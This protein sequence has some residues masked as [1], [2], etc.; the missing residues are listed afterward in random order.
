MVALLNLSGYW[1]V[2]FPKFSEEVNRLQQVD[3]Q[4]T[5]KCATSSPSV[6][7][8]TEPESSVPSQLA[9]FSRCDPY[10][11]SAR[12]RFRRDSGPGAVHL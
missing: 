9:Y 12:F 4:F 2:G 1:N 8:A 10:Q 5:L 7:H 6:T 3:R 11:V